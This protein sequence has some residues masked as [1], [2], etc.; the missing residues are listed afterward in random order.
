MDQ[1]S[2]GRGAAKHTVEHSTTI[3]KIFLHVRFCLSVFYHLTREVQITEDHREGQLVSVNQKFQSS[4]PPSYCID[5]NAQ[6]GQCKR[7]P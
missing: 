7:A 5:A 2:K 3:S 1:I 6:T 4:S